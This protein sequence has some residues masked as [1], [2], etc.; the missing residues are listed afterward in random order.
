[1][2]REGIQFHWQ[3]NNYKSFDD[4]LSTLSSR[5]RKQIKKE[6]ECLKINNLNVKLLTGDDL[7]K[8][9]FEFFY[10]CYLDTTGRKWGST[11]LK[12]EFFMNI[13]K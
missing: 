12:K 1:M 11:Y 7:Q 9:D 4:F 10:E 5:K 8:E 13:L 2:I 6:R 3:N